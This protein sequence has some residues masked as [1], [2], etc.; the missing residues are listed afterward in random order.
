[1]NSTRRNAW[2]FIDEVPITPSSRNICGALALSGLFFAL[3]DLS[4]DGNTF[5]KFGTN[6]GTNDR[7]Q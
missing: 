1:M 7:S 5:V 3:V 4:I 2:H 6:R